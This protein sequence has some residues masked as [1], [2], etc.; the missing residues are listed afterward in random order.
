M[1][2]RTSLTSEILSHLLAF[3]CKAS[4]R[5]LRTVP[6]FVRAT[7]RIENP[8][9]YKRGVERGLGYAIHSEAGSIYCTFSLYALSS[10]NAVHWSFLS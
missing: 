1:I 2:S 5:D 10:Y 3:R 4:I 7:S 9:L 6:S 8:D